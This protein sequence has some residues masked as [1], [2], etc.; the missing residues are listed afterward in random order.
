[1]YMH[2]SGGVHKWVK[3]YFI[4][5]CFKQLHVRIVIVYNKTVLIP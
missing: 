4:V 2:A 1:M 3:N 5:V